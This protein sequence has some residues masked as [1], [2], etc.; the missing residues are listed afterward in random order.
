M[1]TQG[2]SSDDAQRASSERWCCGCHQASIWKLVWALMTAV[3]LTASGIA[4]NLPPAPANGVLDE[5][6][7]FASHERDALVLR[8]RMVRER[9]ALETYVATLAF[10]PG[11]GL[12][13][14][15]QTLAR[16]W[17]GGRPGF[18]AVYER[19]G[20]E[21]SFAGMP[22]AALPA[23]RLREAFLAGQEALRSQ[24]HE[25]APGERLAAGIEAVAAVLARTT[26]GSPALVSPA[27][28]D[29]SSGA[30]AATPP[31]P[32]DGLVDEAG[33]FTAAEAADLKRELA[34]FRSRCDADLHVVTLS[35][36][37]SVDAD[38]YAAHL[39]RAWLKGRFGAVLV[40]NRGVAVDPAAKRTEA[41]LGIAGTSDPVQWLT[42]E[43]L[44]KAILRAR[45]AHADLTEDGKN[46]A[47]GVAAA[48]RV[49]A[50]AM[51]RFGE[52][53]RKTATEV[54]SP[55][56]WRVFTGVAGAFFVG[57]VLLFIFHRI[58][59]SLERRTLETF[60][61]PDV[62]VPQRLGAPE[63]GGVHASVR[64]SAPTRRE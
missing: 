9:H 34:A 51:E 61:F 20:G 48:V 57:S 26:G 58:Q 23:E 18:V 64:F 47:A 2:P 49:M 45:T 10:A 6:G 38:T 8:L 54:T 5:S 44:G 55:D 63:G 15:G 59:E 33:I 24:S 36:L 13:R 39:A 3:V 41:P 32:A 16:A 50:D 7:V 60:H 53:M 40:L 19:G 37:P 14:H 25:A 1:T 43:G 11:D 21:M 35:F 30:A 29:N 46:Q 12:E 31:A 56:Q 62:Q 28:P 52:P 4:E 42:A 22:S 27:L 17:L